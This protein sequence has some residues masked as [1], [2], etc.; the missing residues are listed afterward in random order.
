MAAGAAINV[1]GR[2]SRAGGFDAIERTGATMLVGNPPL[3][4]EVL[5]E[6]RAR[7]CPP[8]RLRVA[9]SGGAPLPL[10]VKKAWRDELRLPI[11]ESYGQSEL[12][13]FMALGRP[14]LEPDDARLA[15][16]GRPL[17]DK[18]VRI[19]GTGDRK[20]PPGEVGEV[21]L[22]G[23]FMHGYWNRPEKTAETLRGGWLRSGD[24]GVIDRHGC[25]SLRSRAAELVTV[26]GR[27]WYPRD[28]EEALT[29]LPGITAAALVG[30]PDPALGQRPVAFV[31]VA[32]GAQVDP[33]TAARMIA[34]ACPGPAEVL[35]LVVIEAMPMTPTGKIAKAELA[36]RA[37]AMHGDGSER[38]A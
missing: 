19:L 9:L 28:V 11:A 6:S 23:G 5:E 8:G 3:L 30:V 2:W 4:Q 24:L 13:G 17:P 15:P 21:V 16:I 38:A 37:R 34:G 25:L 18:E 20:L 14:D 27:P 10:A 36:A 7:G 22:R 29:T 35:R 12:G 1:M 26:A 31:T 33:A 32:A